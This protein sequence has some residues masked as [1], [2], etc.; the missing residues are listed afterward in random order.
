MQVSRFSELDL[1]GDKFIIEID[2]SHPCFFDQTQK[3]F[4]NAVY[5]NFRTEI[6][7]IYL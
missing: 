1:D 6:R 7:K 4:L 2:L 3:F 5:K